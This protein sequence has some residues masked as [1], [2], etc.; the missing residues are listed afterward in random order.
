MTKAHGYRHCCK[1]SSLTT[2]APKIILNNLR[3]EMILWKTEHYPGWR[4]GI[5]PSSKQPRIPPFLR[6]QNSWWDSSAKQNRIVATWRNQD[7][8]ARFFQKSPESLQP[9][10][11]LDANLP[12]QSHFSLFVGFEGA[13]DGPPVHPKCAAQQCRRWGPIEKSTTRTLIADMTD[14]WLWLSGLDWI[15]EL[16]ITQIF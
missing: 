10:D 6:H 13:S 1:W 3:N 4:W 8:V 7:Q 2:S 5:S 15:L 9:T 14:L 11:L 12:L 16:Q